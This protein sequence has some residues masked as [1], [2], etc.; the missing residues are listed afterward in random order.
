MLLL[1]AGA[2]RRFGGRDK[3][4]ARLLGRP[5]IAHAL[6]RAREAA[7]GRVILVAPAALWP[8]D[9]NVLGVRPRE[10]RLGLGA[11]LLAGLAALRPIEREVLILLADMPFACAPRRLRLRP[12]EDAARP[13]HRGLPGHPMLVRADIARRLA[14]KA[15][16]GLAQS[17]AADRVALVA[18][19][20]GHLLDIDTPRA[21]GR[22]RRRIAGAGRAFV[23][24]RGVRSRK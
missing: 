8:R 19:D 21:L 5:L 22:A 6:C 14:A 13:V 12:G 24:A 3:L 11:S 18:G 1:A 23:R 7:A 4:R 10:A 20:A 16:R 17:L 2:S 9:G 15:D